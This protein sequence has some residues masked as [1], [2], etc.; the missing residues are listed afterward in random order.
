MSQ[1]EFVEEVEW[2]LFIWD[3]EA[4]HLRAME[5]EQRRFSEVLAKAR[6][7]FEQAKPRKE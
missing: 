5:E 7:E 1:E 3:L 6:N 2:R 4:E